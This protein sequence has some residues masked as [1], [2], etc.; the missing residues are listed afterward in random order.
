MST[1]THGKK[2]DGRWPAL[3]RLFLKGKVCA[4]CGGKKKLE[5]HHILPFH[6]YPAR[7][8]DPNNL[9]PLCEGPGNC[10]LSFGHLH[11]FSSYNAD[12]V[13]DAAN[14]AF[15]IAHRPRA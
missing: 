1:K 13:N 6:L 4:V 5:A 15:K 14:F 7:E 12:V 11:N 2:R 9:I 8:L 3:R 10:H